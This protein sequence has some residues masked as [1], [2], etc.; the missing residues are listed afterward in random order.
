MPWLTLAPRAGVV[1]FRRDGYYV[2]YSL[3]TE[4]IAPRSDSLLPFLE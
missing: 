1:E 3:A 4:R 2:L